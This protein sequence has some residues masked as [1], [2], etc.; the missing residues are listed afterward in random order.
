MIVRERP[1]ALALLYIMRGSIVPTIAPR[2]GIV[3]LIAVAI[4]GFAKI[5]PGVFRELSPAPLTL[6]GL[7]LSIFLGFRNNACYDRWWEGRRQWGQLVSESYGFARD[8]R[9][10]LEPAAAREAGLRLIAFS[11]ALRAQLRHAAKEPTPQAILQEQAQV[12]ADLARG[13][14]LTDIQYRLFSDRLQAVTNIQLACER[15]GSTP[16]PFAYSLLVHRTA[17]LF[18]LFAPFGLVGSLGLATPVAAAVLAYAF[19]GLD[20]LGEE[21]EDPFSEHQNALPLN[22]LQRSVERAVLSTL[23]ETPPPPLEPVDHLLL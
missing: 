12:F 8:A 5:E 18:C 15:L 6:T 7:A 3:V 20:A 13:G 11:E 1:S 4:T 17:W 19:F 2:V 21:L 9:A 10:L 14:A 22:A 16:L 23:G